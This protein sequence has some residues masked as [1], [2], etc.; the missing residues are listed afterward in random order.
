MPEG[1][2]KP[3]QRRVLIALCRPLLFGA[4]GTP[5]SNRQIADEVS[6]TEDAIKKHLGVLFTHFG[7]KALTPNDKRSRLALIVLQHG[8]VSRRDYD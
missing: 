2:L 5:A 3:M 6:L 4:S 8:L 1:E 7:V